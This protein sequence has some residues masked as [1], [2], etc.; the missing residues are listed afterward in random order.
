MIGFWDFKFSG[1]PPLLSFGVMP[2]GDRSNGGHKN[3]HLT[4]LVRRQCV[5]SALT[6]A[7]CSWRVRDS[8]RQT[9]SC[10]ADFGHRPTNLLC[11]G[12]LFR[13]ESPHAFTQPRSSPI[14]RD[15]SL[16]VAGAMFLI[17]MSFGFLP[18]TFA[19][20]AG[21]GDL[22]VSAYAPFVVLATSRRTP[23][24]HTH[25]VLL[26]VPGLLDFVGAIGGG[27]LSGRSPLGMLRGDVTTD[28]MQELPLSM[29][30]MFAVPFWIVLQ[31]ISLIKLRNL[32]AAAEE[33]AA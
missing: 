23:G 30:P 13:P 4:G 5:G 33:S 16:A 26:N 21:I 32:Q 6:Y 1:A 19:W 24:W 27:V 10:V 7:E 8:P 22:I 14:D 29:I 3:Q 31:I 25:V 15:A 11:H 17:L 2:Q 18:G 28:I 20:P 12:V 9:T